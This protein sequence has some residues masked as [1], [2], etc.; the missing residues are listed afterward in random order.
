NGYAFIPDPADGL[1]LEGVELPGDPPAQDAKP[2]PNFAP[3]AV[4]KIPVTLLLDE[5][6][7]RADANWQ[8]DARERLAEASGVIET[9]CGVRFEFAG[10]ARWRSEEHT[11]ELQS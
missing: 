5:A 9:A 8:P 10:F 11:S 1:R 3:P 6:D 4:L 2:D 7:P